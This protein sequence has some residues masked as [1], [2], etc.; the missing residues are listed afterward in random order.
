MKVLLALLFGL[1]PSAMTQDRV[2]CRLRRLRL[3]ASS[4]ASRTPCARSPTSGLWRPPS[5]PGSTSACSFR[6]WPISPMPDHPHGDSVAPS[7]T[8]TRRSTTFSNRT[9]HVPSPLTRSVDNLTR[10]DRSP[11]SQVPYPARAQGGTGKRTGQVV[12]SAQGNWR[13]SCLISIDL[14]S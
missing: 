11:V 13:H 4:I 8:S 2:T 9:I 1:E 7:T 3:R 10:R 14:G 5:S 6:D 12:E